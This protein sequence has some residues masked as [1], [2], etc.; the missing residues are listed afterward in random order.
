[1]WRLV[2]ARP[3]QIPPSLQTPQGAPTPQSTVTSRLRDMGRGVA[4][5]LLLALAAGVPPA[6]PDRGREGLDVPRRLHVRRLVQGVMAPALLRGGPMP[7]EDVRPVVGALRT[8]LA[9]RDET[10]STLLIGLA[11]LA[12][13]EAGRQSL[14]TPGAEEAG[15]AITAGLQTR[16][17][18]PL[19][20]PPLPAV[21]PARRLVN[22]AVLTRTGMAG[23]RRF[24]NVGE[25]S[26]AGHAALA[27]SPLL[28]A[29][30]LASIVLACGDEAT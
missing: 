7:P 29:A 25:A 27:V 23:R 26:S 30:R 19:I 15:W 12:I 10:A 21:F 18:I 6:A 28:A 22:E 17:L 13:P 20:A 16:P 3:P 1:M 5:F 4:P 8:P 14:L 24:P 9:R 2:E 11:R